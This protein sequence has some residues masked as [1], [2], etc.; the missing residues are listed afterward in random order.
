MNITSLLQEAPSRHRTRPKPWDESVNTSKGVG[1]PWVPGESTGTGNYSSGPPESMKNYQMAQDY[2][3]PASS[4][5]SYYQKQ[6]GKEPERVGLSNEITRDYSMQEPARQHSRM[7]LENAE[8]DWPTNATSGRAGHGSGRI[9]MA[10]DPSRSE[11]LDLHG[12]QSQQPELFRPSL[13][14]LNSLESLPPPPRTPSPVLD[15]MELGTFIYPNLPFPVRRS[16]APFN[17]RTTLKVIVPAS[18]IPTVA[19][20]KDARARR[21]WGGVPQTDQRKIFTDDSDVLFAA[22]H[23]GI[24]T[25]NSDPLPSRQD[26]QLDLRLYPTSD[27]GRY[28]GGPGEHGLTSASWGNSHEGCAFVILSAVWVPNRTA[29]SYSRQNRKARMAEEA[30]RRAEVMNGHAFSMT[31]ST[32]G[33]RPL[34]PLVPALEMHPLEEELAS[35]SVTGLWQNQAGFKYDPMTFYLMLFSPHSSVSLEEPS[36]RPGAPYTVPNRALPK[37]TGTDVI[38]ENPNNSVERLVLVPKQKIGD[39]PSH[40]ETPRRPVYDLFRETKLPKGQL[41]QTGGEGVIS[42]SSEGD[43]TPKAVTTQAN[44]E[45]QDGQW[46]RTLLQAGLDV[47]QLQFRQEGI[48]VQEHLY[49]VMCWRFLSPKNGALGNKEAKSRIV[50]PKRKHKKTKKLSSKTSKHQKDTTQTTSSVAATDPPTTI[51]TPDPTPIA[52]QA[53]GS[54]VSPTETKAPI[55]EAPNKT[56][57]GTVVADTDVHMDGPPV[58]DEKEEG[59]LSG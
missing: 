5:G 23:S 16:L 49:P 26:L 7:E 53:E 38:L 35:L 6:L 39:V 55:E 58:E 8:K 11:P 19:V 59:E 47:E 3:R 50:Q 45:S 24:I 51:S 33:L 44:G 28:L 15:P 20:D 57:K 32:P 41:S 54:R 36:T 14:T 37:R 56:D 1:E 2:S 13:A 25:L 42:I 21:I 29:R 40:A 10:E 9:V 46:T 4:A 30:R 27:S 43:L 18:H 22:L 34:E 52:S 17:R 12:K 48:T 31:L